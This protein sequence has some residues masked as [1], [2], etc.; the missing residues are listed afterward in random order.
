[1]DTPGPQTPTLFYSRD[2][3]AGSSYEQGTAMLSKLPEH[4]HTSHAFSTAAGWSL[5]ALKCLYD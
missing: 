1:M 2:Q 5:F 4:K 3:K